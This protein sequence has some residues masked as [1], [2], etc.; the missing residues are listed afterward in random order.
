MRVTAPQRAKRQN[1]K[2][3]QKQKKSKQQR[4]PTPKPRGP[5]H[6]P[7][8]HVSYELHNN[9][10]YHPEDKFAWEVADDALGMKRLNTNT[11]LRE[12]ALRYANYQKNSVYAKQQISF[13]SHTVIPNPQFKEQFYQLVQ[14][15]PPTVYE[16]DIYWYR[17][18]QF[19]HI[20]GF[21]CLQDM[22]QTQIDC[23][24][25]TVSDPNYVPKQ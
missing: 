16:Q 21:A 12:D 11:A 10:A 5:L 14:D 18:N 15:P 23:R 17:P 3:Q 19:R 8:R 2:P 25:Q 6:T 20:E 24:R 1:A 7:K 22:T 13:A 4:A 9:V